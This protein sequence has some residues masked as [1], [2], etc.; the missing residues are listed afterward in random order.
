MAQRRRQLNWLEKR[1]ES[2]AKSKAGGWWFVNVAM[3]IDRRLLP[4]TRGRFSSAPGNQILLLETVGRKSGQQRQ[5]PLVYVTDGDRLVIVASKAGSTKHPAWYHNLRANPG[6]K[7]LAP[8][9][10]GQ[11]TARVAEGDERARLWDEVVDYYAGYETYQGRTDGREIP[12]VVLE[13]LGAA[14]SA[15]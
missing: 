8:R 11:Y 9:R 10:S 6:V 3:R 5:T 4:L 14:R 1:L 15:S 13:P 12:V 7:V 2:F